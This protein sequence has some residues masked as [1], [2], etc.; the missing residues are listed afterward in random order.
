MF[1]GILIRTMQQPDDKN[2]AKPIRLYM[3]SD[4]NYAKTICVH[5]SSDQNDANNLNS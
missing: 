1:I 3:A 4:D 5:M 2:G